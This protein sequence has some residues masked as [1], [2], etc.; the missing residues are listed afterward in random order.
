MLAFPKHEIPIVQVSLLTSLDPAEH[1]RMGQALR[2]LRMEENVLVVGSG[3]HGVRFQPIASFWLEDAIGLHVCNWLGPSK[4]V[5][6]HVLYDDLFLSLLFLSFAFV[7]RC[8]SCSLRV[9]PYL[10]GVPFSAA[11]LKVVP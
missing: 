11:T 5:I 7:L 4:R 6:L 8:I 1:L 3:M 9:V 2:P 10:S